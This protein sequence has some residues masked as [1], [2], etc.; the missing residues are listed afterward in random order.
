MQADD[1]NPDGAAPVAP[2]VT[3][4]RS[5]AEAATQHIISGGSSIGPTIMTAR[6]AISSPALFPDDPKAG[7]IIASAW[8]RRNR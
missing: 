2:H 1:F 7:S 3:T 6:I 4:L 8:A 5:L